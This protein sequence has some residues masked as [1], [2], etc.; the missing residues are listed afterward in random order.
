MLIGLIAILP[1]ANAQDSGSGAP[2]SLPANTTDQPD[3]AREA[4]EQ[5]MHK[6]SLDAAQAAKMYTIQTRKQHN[7]TE[8]ANL[9]TSNPPLYF[10]KLKSIQKGTLASIQ[11]LLT[12]TEQLNLFRETQAEQRRLRAEKQ[13]AL[14]AEGV[15]PLEIE[16]ALTD[17]YFE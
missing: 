13:R 3:L 8:I 17:I 4:T 16:A 1:F 11:R 12:T 14:K 6:Y 5:L 15:G 9:K 7:L 10:Q 2:P